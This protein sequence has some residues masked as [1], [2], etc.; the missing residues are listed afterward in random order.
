[1]IAAYVDLARANAP[2]F[3]LC[4]LF[5]AAA[6]AWVTP[7]SIARW[8]LGLAAALAALAVSL[9]MCW[10]VLQFGDVIEDSNLLVLDGVAV[11][12]APVILIVT[13]LSILVSR[14]RADPA[15]TYNTTLHLASAGGWLGALFAHDWIGAVVGAQVGWLAA[16]LNVAMT[17]ERAALNG[18]LRMVSAGGACAGLMML[19][20][21][22][23]VAA[24][25]GH[26]VAAASSAAIEAPQMA[27][28]G[29]ALLIAPLLLMAGA[30]PMHAWMG[31][32][33][34]KSDSS[35]GLLTA[36]LG[37]LAV[38]ARLT[39]IAAAAPAI[40]EGVSLLLLI[41]GAA[42]VAFGS[43]QAIGAVNARRLIAYAIVAQIGCIVLALALE[44]PAGVSAALVQI[45]ALAA[46][47]SALLVGLQATR[48][49]AVTSLDGLGRRAPLAG[50]A[51]TLGALSFMGAPLTLGFL[52]RWRLIEASVGAGWWWATA[53]AIV[54]SLAAVFYG[55]RLIERLFFRRATATSEFDNSLWRF[56]RAPAL[57]LAIAAIAYGLGPGL[58]LQF[59]DRAS[60]I[61]LGL[62]V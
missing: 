17:P 30:A 9:D 29:F 56:A 5:I 40:A 19:G 51:I 21:G 12:V 7:S 8:V 25:G 13:L 35:L 10:R 1:M 39:A 48:Q 55:G 32:A 41:V 26:Q 53:A 37:A 28:L 24:V 52:G 3:V 11:F 27:T 23:V 62:G 47:A 58:L 36:A 57:I 43:V 38:I 49:T 22:L 14:N 20:A 44:S 61:A 6:L 54:T 4:A 2:I 46:G 33:Y 34:G 59:A 50:L 60:A 16:T 45:L 15:S 42:S 18:A 31:A